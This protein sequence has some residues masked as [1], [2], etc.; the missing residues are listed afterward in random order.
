MSHEC[1]YWNELLSGLERKVGSNHQ[2]ISIPGFNYDVRDC[3]K[4]VVYHTNGGKEA[5]KVML[6]W[7]GEKWMYDTKPVFELSWNG[8]AELENPNENKVL[9]EYSAALERFLSE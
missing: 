9:K 5:V 2:D 3:G 4:R 6:D 1:S 7:N 8:S